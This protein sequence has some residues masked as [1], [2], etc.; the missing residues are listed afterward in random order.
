M[1]TIT[2]DNKVNIIY[3]TIILLALGGIILSG[4]IILT[5][6]T[7]P[8]CKAVT[9]TVNYT[10]EGRIDTM[11][12]VSVVPFSWNKVNAILD[13]QV[14]Q[15]GEKYTVSRLLTAEYVYENDHYYLQNKK[16]IRH[17]RDNVQGEEANR[18]MPG[19]SVKN[20]F[21]KIEKVNDSSY[22]FS[23]NNSPFFVCTKVR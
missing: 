3:C 21:M 6:H 4:Y 11:L 8:E 17:P 13:G 14:I 15:G 23:D 19:G 22:L 1:K 9:K 12:M 7:I 2:Y 18:V 20:S 5:R 16:I 10:K